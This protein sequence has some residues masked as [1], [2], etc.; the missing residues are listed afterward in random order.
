MTNPIRR[1]I[2]GKEDA[3][4]ACLKTELGETVLADLRVFC[5]G[6]QSNFSTDALE[7]ARMEGRREV[8]T[9]VMNYLNVDY[10][11]YYKYEEEYYDE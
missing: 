5:N 7:M 9:R 2:K 8:F 6:T 1:F 3:Y 10:S 11:E 4:R